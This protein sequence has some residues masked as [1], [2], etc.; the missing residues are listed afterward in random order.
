MEREREDRPLIGPQ[1]ARAEWPSNA[2]W[3]SAVDR[4][5]LERNIAT[6]LARLGQNPDDLPNWTPDL[7]KAMH[8]EVGRCTGLI[9]GDEAQLHPGLGMAWLVRRTRGEAKLSEI[10]GDPLF[11]RPGLFL[12]PVPG[13]VTKTA[14]EPSRNHHAEER[15]RQDTS[16]IASERLS[17]A[18]DS[19][20]GRLHERALPGGD[21]KNSLLR[22]SYNEYG[23]LRILEALE[24]QDCQQARVLL[25]SGYESPVDILLESERVAE[26][27]VVDASRTAKET[28]LA[29]FGSH[30]QSEKLVVASIDLSPLHRSMQERIADAIGQARADRPTQ[31]E[32][33]AYFRSVADQEAWES[34][35][36]QTDEFDAAHLPFIL[37]SLHLSAA[38]IAMARIGPG[39]HDYEEYLGGDVLKHPYAVEAASSCTSFALDEV[40]RIVRPRGPY[41]A[42]IWA[43]PVLGPKGPSI[44]LSDTEVS[45][46]L[47]DLVFAGMQH[48]LSGNP[49]PGLLHTVGH[50]LLGQGI[51]S[52]SQP[53]DRPVPA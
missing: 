31:E 30:P 5:V 24:R 48:E 12:G 1:F 32:A 45:D 7:A 51:E 11:L 50:V 35:P 40:R 27:L 44:R 36:F 19:Q 8:A 16:R 49:Q 38:T 37:G 6:V 22:A 52:L 4:G 39:Y 26:V 17:A 28:V 10:I 25:C 14:F 29:R 13:V 46:E 43:R 20:W 2:D 33:L 47:F 23:L 18:M 15:A 41:V 42:N 3:I 21:N 9:H 53:V 34:F